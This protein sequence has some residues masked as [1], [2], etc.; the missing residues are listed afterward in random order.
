MIE[1]TTVKGVEDYPTLSRGVKRVCREI[2]LSG[3]MVLSLALGEKEWSILANRWIEGDG[4]SG[5]RI[6]PAELWFGGVRVE[7]TQAEST[8]VVVSATS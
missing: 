3:H 7:R 2:R 8:C 1:N 4:Q 5:R 6:L